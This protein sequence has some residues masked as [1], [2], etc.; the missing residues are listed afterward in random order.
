MAAI[1]ERKDTLPLDSIINANLMFRGYGETTETLIEIF[2]PIFDYCAGAID[3]AGYT[4]GAFDAEY[5]PH[6]IKFMCNSWYLLRQKRCAIP[7]DMAICLGLI[8]KTLKFANTAR[9]G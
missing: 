7:E 4:L 6:L 5:V 2:R 8:V 1:V 3:S 9:S